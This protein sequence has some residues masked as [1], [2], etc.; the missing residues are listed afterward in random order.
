MNYNI[1]LLIASVALNRGL[2]IV[3]IHFEGVDG[4]K[5]YD[6]MIRFSLARVTVFYREK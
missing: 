5:K 6:A 4:S 3:E 2:Y 1:C